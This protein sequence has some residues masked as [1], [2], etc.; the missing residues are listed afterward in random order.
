MICVVGIFSRFHHSRHWSP[1]KVKQCLYQ[2]LLKMLITTTKEQ[3]FLHMKN[4]GPNR[5]G[6]RL[7]VYRFW[8]W[9][10]WVTENYLCISWINWFRRS[11]TNY[12]TQINQFKPKRMAI[13][14]LSALARGVSLN[15]FRQ[16]VIAVTAI[17]N[18]KR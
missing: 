17:Q 10:W 14:S 16:F 13:D 9:K 5:L 4:L 7:V 12:K 2:N 1:G 15:A 11:L 3:Y 18:K 8:K 6:M